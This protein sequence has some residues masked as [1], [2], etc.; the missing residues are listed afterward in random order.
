MQD[1][2]M[3]WLIQ[4]KRKRNYLQ[5]LNAEA[6]LGGGE[7]RIKKQHDQGKYTAREKNSKISRCRLFYGV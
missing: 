7:L 6:L 2:E 1:K 3:R 5:E 4:T